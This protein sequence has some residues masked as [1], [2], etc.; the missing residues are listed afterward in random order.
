MPHPRPGPRP[1]LDLEPD[2]KPDVEEPSWRLG[3]A[4]PRVPS[5]RSFDT[6]GEQYPQIARER[7][8]TARGGADSDPGEVARPALQ[9][10]GAPREI[11]REI[12]RSAALP[13]DPGAG[14]RAAADRFEKRRWLR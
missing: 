5:V 13:S 12:P 14:R 9:E 3:L 8:R 10:Q 1:A 6:G 7:T 4:E 2:P 11:P